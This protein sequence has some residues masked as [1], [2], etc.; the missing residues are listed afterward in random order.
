MEMIL[1]SMDL[2]LLCMVTLHIKDEL[3]TTT[4]I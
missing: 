3:L 2:L 1:A 4:I